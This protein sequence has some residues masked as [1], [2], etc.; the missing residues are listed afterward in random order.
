MKTFLTTTALVIGLAVPAIAQDMTDGLSEAEKARVMML[1]PQADLSSLTDDQVTAIQLTLYNGSD[2]EQRQH[3][4]AIIEGD[5][6]SYPRLSAA[7]EAEIRK[8]APDVDLSTLRRDQ[9]A[10]LQATLNSG[11]DG[12]RRQHISAIL[13]ADESAPVTTLSE[14]EKATLQTW[15]PNEDLSSLTNAQKVAIQMTLNTGEDSETRQH[16]RAI[17]Q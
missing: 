7:Q 12:E 4:T 15:F 9:V 11:D 13:A 3:L 10:A 14:A 16:I 6:A 8:V 1:V 5:S 17:L 2:G